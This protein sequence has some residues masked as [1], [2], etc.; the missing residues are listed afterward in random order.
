MPI[1]LIHNVLPGLTM[2]GHLSL[3]VEQ[4]VDWNPVLSQFPGELTGDLKAVVICQPGIGH[5]DQ[6]IQV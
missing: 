5:R 4:E 2:P 1:G 6:Q 3:G